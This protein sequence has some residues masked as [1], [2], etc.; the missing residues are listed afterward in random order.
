M[1]HMDVRILIVD[2]LLMNIELL[3]EILTPEG[4]TVDSAESGEEALDKVFNDPP[5][6]I[7]LDVMMPKM[8]GYEV[9]R[10]IRENKSL[11]YVPIIYIT[12]SELEQE[13][14]IE[15]LGAGGDDYIRKPFEIGELLERIISCLRVKALYDELAKTKA[16][17]SRY[18]SL[19]TLRMVESKIH[20]GQAEPVDRDAY[21]TILFSDIRGFTQISER[22][23]PADVFAKLNNNIGKQ[24]KII[25]KY[26]GI[27]EK[28]NGD[29]VMAVFDGPNMA[30]NA[31]GCALEIIQE[32]SKSELNGE[33]ELFNVGIGINTGQIYIGSLGNEFFRDY[34][35]IGNTV[36][37]AA[38]LCGLA[39]KLQVLFTKTTLTSISQEKFCFQSI[40]KKMLKGLSKPIEVF[41]ATL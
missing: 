29:E 1:K 2:D 37:I 8:N 24:L 12:A 30:D 9:C 19:S 7:L 21:V 41:K 26:Q 16:E 36:N 11:P 13:N 40:G 4:Y 38:R 17:L 6:L 25:E 10:R 14:V 32:L 31:L 20:H 39:D 23:A 15:G 28:L 18:V 35:V 5:D 27:I 22:M 34:T 33:S 3:E